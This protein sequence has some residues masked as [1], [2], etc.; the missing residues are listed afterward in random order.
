MFRKIG[1]MTI[2]LQRSVAE[3]SAGALIR[4]SAHA[5]ENR[6]WGLFVYLGARIAMLQER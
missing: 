3:L 2:H 1:T 4:Q 5:P 6:A